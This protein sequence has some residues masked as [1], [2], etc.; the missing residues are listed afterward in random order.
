[1][2]HRSGQNNPIIAETRERGEEEIIYYENST[3][4]CSISLLYSVPNETQPRG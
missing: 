2:M 3:D 1:M 4:N